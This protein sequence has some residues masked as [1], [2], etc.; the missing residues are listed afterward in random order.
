MRLPIEATVM[1]KEGGALT[2]RIWLAADGTVRTDGSACV[3]SW[4]RA[5]RVRFGSAGELANQI[6][7][8]GQSE[9]I[10]LGA[11][12][13]DL[14]DAV[15]VVAK[16]RLN[17]AAGVI[18]RT[19]DFIA[20]RPG[21]PA[22][23][24]ADYDTKGMPDAVRAG[25]EALGDF[26]RALVSVLPGLAGAAHVIRQSTSAGLYDSST[27]KKLR[28]SDGTHAYILLQ[29]GAD[30]ER[31]L[32]AL[33]ARC[34]LAGFGWMM[35]G[36]G[37]QLLE[38]SIIDRVVG[39]PERLVFEGPA[40]LD[41]PLAQDQARR[42][43]IATDGVAL[44]TIT[45]C[46]PLSIREKAKLSE[47]RAREKQRL[48]PEAAK[49]REAFIVLPFDDEELAG[50]TVADV[51]ADP[52]LFEGATLADPLEGAEYGL[53]KARI[54]LRANGTPW[55]NSFAH[56]RTVYELRFDYCAAA[57][58]LEKERDQAPDLF[59]D[60]VLNG[61]LTKAEIERLKA[62]AVKNSGVGPRALTA[63]LK[64]AHQEWEDA[65]AREERE[66]RI[67]ERQDQRP[68]IPAPAPDAE[69]LPTMAALNGVL[70]ASQAAEPPMR[71]FEGYLTEVRTRPTQ[72]LHGLTA[73]GANHEDTDATRLPPPEY[74]ALCRLSEVELAELIE[75][76]IEFVDNEGRP[77]HLGAPFVKHYLQ[78][79]DGALPMVSGICTLPIV[80]P[81]GGILK[82]PGLDRRFNIVFRI[83][84]EL[85]AL[86]PDPKEC[87]PAAVS[88]AM[89]FLT[90]EW[91][92]DVAA[93]YAGRCVLIAD[94]LTIIERQILPMR[95][96][97]FI[98]S[99]K[100]G[101]GKTTALNMISCAVLGQL[102]AA[103]AWSPSKEERRKALFAYFLDGVPML[104]WDNIA[105]GTTISCP[106]IEKS[107]TAE[108]YTDR[109]L[110][111]SEHRL[112]PVTTIQHFTG[113]NIAPGGDLS[114]RSLRF[115]L[116]VDRPDPENRHFQHPDPIGWTSAHRGQILQAL[117]TLLLGNP[118]R[119]GKRTGPLETRFKEWHDVVG[120]AVEFAA[121]VVSDEVRGFVADA[122]SV[123]TPTP[124]SF[125]EMFLAGEEGDEES[126]GLSALLA[127]LLAKWGETFFKAS[128][129]SR[130][131]EPDG[132]VP[133]SQDA[134]EMLAT[135]ERAT[136]D[137]PLRRVTPTS[138][139]WRL[140]KLTNTP[141]RVGNETLVLICQPVR[142]KGD[143][144]CIKIL[145]R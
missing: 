1:A 27:T 132:G 38:R 31:F 83:P 141:V 84:A 48:A 131:L 88:Q 52:A 123:C 114:S 6:A 102:A 50:K 60:Y 59:I 127:M 95:P 61:D 45:A 2:K 68:Q 17:D 81:N 58:L 23:T 129:V 76:H 92:C 79:Q 56:G 103:A 39:T 8:L 32:K 57:A 63:M 119:T 125:R 22:Y 137:K 91:L 55:I 122:P 51:L 117:Y 19:R 4:G 12:R 53:G 124:I 16:H 93:D 116:D 35:V 47:L 64:T 54:M 138:V 87:T 74:P 94:A 15:S 40:V 121:E 30:G 18:A 101:G 25:I 7:S 29:D 14:P 143:C 89:R 33:H 78:R 72:G 86:L 70:G 90:H 145:S 144:Y 130:Y 67:A 96:A 65:R 46:P 128:D 97:F 66:R 44:D 21:V 115:F 109:L 135:L 126:T 3:M 139:S 82:G 28:G 112:V 9:A 41:P 105:R 49:A 108:L 13:S 111:V 5:R 37:G 106:S 118:R 100:R 73:F 11:M 140:K 134:R 24:L 80:L 113:N 36:A 34:W 42:R 26:W 142:N 99:G 10:T 69:W 20:F 107:L 62:I 133:P 104:V 71:D 43:P 136:G 85:R 75:R 98:V 110:G 120:S 77:V